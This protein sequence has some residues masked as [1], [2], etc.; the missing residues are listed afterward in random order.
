MSIFGFPGDPL[1]HANPGLLDQ[2]LAIEWVRD[3][4]ALFGGDPSRITIFGQSAGGVSVDDY[5]YAWPSD[6]IVH[7]LIAQ[8]GTTTGIGNRTQEQANEFWFAAAKAAG[9]GNSGL[10]AKHV[11]DCMLRVPVEAI[12]GG[13]SAT[14][15]S[16]VTMPYGP[17]ID[18][19]IVFAN[20]TGRKAAALPLLIGSTDFEYGLFELFTDQNVTLDEW[21][22]QG[23]SMFGCPAA[24]RAAASVRDGNPTWRYRYMAAFANTELSTNPPSGAYHEAEVPLVFDTVDQSY[25][26]SKPRE[27]ALGSYLRGAWATF[28]KD[29][30]KG[31]RKYGWPEYQPDKKTLIRLGYRNHIGPNAATVAAYDEGC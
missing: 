18:N 31:L 14:V 1:S 26:K 29:P 2:R 15:N 27:K 9:C 21:K 3:N 8:S 12:L 11:H 22:Q 28:A 5:S 16:P 4:I 30:A 10:S 20:Y 24:R 19:A 25:G 6:P 13:L 7:G 17:T 23:Q